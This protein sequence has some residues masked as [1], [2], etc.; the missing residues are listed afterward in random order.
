MT[1]IFSASWRPNKMCYTYQLCWSRALLMSKYKKE[2]TIWWDQHHP[3]S[4]NNVSIMVHPWCTIEEKL[5]K[6]II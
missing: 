6:L 2:Q 4:Y 5:P 3:N 1:P